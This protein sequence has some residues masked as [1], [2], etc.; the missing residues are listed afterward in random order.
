MANTTLTALA[1]IPSGYRG[2]EKTAEMVRKQIE[3]RFGSKAADDYDP[4]LNART[5]SNWLKVGYRV[6][7]GEKALTSVTVIEKKDAK[8]NIIKKYPKKVCL[9]F[10]S[11]VEP[12]TNS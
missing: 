3:E 7:Q 12:I 11:Q 5:F 4:A 10:Q 6:K 2:S 1:N 8:G 9:F